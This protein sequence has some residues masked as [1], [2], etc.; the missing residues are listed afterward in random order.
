MLNRIPKHALTLSQKFE[1]LQPPS[2][3][4]C[5]RPLNRIVD[6]KDQF[7]A[8]FREHPLTGISATFCLGIFV[9]WMIKRR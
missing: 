9:G 4:W 5:N 8:Y 2:S 7:T 1:T 3:D 6:R